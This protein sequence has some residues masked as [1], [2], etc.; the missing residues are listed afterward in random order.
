MSQGVLF[1]LDFLFKF[2]TYFERDRDSTGRG[3]AERERGERIPSRLR[4]VRAEPGAG[5][6]LASR[7]IVT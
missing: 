2:L 3:E 6:E 4:V 7:E 1:A 5:I